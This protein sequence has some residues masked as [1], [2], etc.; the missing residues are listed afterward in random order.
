VPAGLVLSVPQVLDHPHVRERE[1]TTTF[2]DVAGLDRPLQVL[3]PGF[4]LDG[5]RPTPQLR[6]PRSASTAASCCARR[7][8]TTPRSTTDRAR[9]TR[10]RRPPGRRDR[11]RTMTTPDPFAH[12][13]VVVQDVTGRD[14]FQNVAPWIP[15]EVK[16]ELL[17]GIVGAGRP[18]ARG[19]LV[20]PPEVG[21]AAAR[22]RGGLRRAGRRPRRWRRARRGPSSARWCPTPRASRARRAAASTRSA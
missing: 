21:A 6:P 16:V 1:V 8:S 9:G 13:D 3:R 10:R 22:R 7:A 15:T 18:L 19:H 14:G 4:L 11:R 2:E 17:R 12:L 5:H 20:R